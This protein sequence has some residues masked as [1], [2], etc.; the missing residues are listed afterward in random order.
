[1][2]ISAASKARYELDIDNQAGSER[3]N[4]GAKTNGTMKAVGG[5]RAKDYRED[6]NGFRGGSYVNGEPGKRTAT[7]NKKTKIDKQRGH[8][9]RH[10]GFN[11]RW[12]QMTKEEQQANGRNLRNYEPAPMQV[13]EIAT[14][15]CR[16]AHFAT[17]PPELVERCLKAGCPPGGLVLDIFGGSGTTGMVA[18]YMG[19]DARLIELNEE[20]V[21]IAW[22][23]IKSAAPLTVEIKVENMELF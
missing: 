12:D 15:A 13:W 17:F 2:L 14:A 18:D 19:M 6:A 21:K 4:G 7:G 16:E 20:Y 8:S 1:M 11:D 10:D 23:R 9:R 22:K 3:A 5:P